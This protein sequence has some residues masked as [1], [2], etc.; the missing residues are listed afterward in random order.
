MR[1]FA[2]TAAL[3]TAAL[4]R[5]STVTVLTSGSP[6]TYST[7]EV[8]QISF[9]AEG[10]VTVALVSGTTRE[11]GA[12]EFVSL[13]F[14]S[15]GSGVGM[16]ASPRQV[17]LRGGVLRVEGASELRVSSVSGVAV[18]SSPGCEID[19]SSLGAGVYIVNVDGQ[20]FKLVLP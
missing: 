10:G 5:G 7:A 9:P 1:F 2:V 18:A 17:S 20:T 12:T 6:E 13:V 11:F 8:E 15:S 14:E 3:L 16:C 19:L 4:L